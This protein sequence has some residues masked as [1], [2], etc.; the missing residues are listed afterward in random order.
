MAEPKPSG[1]D[2]EVISFLGSVERR[3]A[4]LDGVDGTCPFDPMSIAGTFI[5][6]MQHPTGIVQVCR[7]YAG[8][9]ISVEPGA[10][11]AWEA[12]NAAVV[13]VSWPYEL[14]GVQKMAAEINRREGV[15]PCP[16]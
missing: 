9:M 1:I 14:A 15:M 13:A 4:V 16:K 12:I 5:A 10:R 8:A 2:P 11:K 6:M 3:L 7:A